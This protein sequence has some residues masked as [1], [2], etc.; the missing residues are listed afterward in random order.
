MYLNTTPVDLNSGIFSVAGT[1][2]KDSPGISGAS[3]SS[4]Y[5]GLWGDGSPYLSQ[6]IYVGNTVFAGNDNLYV[7]SGSNFNTSATPYDWVVFQ[8]NNSGVVGSVYDSN[9]T[10]F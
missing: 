8:I 2:V 7:A 6:T 10:P 3:A 9:G 1:N 5:L 4:G